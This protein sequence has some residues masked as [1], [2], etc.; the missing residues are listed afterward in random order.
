MYFL[1]SSRE[2]ERL[3]ASGFFPQVWFWQEENVKGYEPP[4][5]GPADL[6]GRNLSGHRMDISLTGRPDGKLR[7]NPLKK[8]RLEIKTSYVTSCGSCISS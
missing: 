5:A 7:N 4:R 1:V 2:I 3:R 8:L 6:T